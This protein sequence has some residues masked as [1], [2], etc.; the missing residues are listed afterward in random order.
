M[1]HY[2]LLFWILGLVLVSCS[3]DVVENVPEYYPFKDSKS[4]NWGL[5]SV[6]GKV[7]IA[8][9]FKQEPSPVI[10]GIFFVAKDNYYEIYSVSDPTK[11]IGDK[12]K[13]IATFTGKYTP[14]VMKGE[15]IKYI[16]KKGNLKY[17]LPLEYREASIFNKGY[18]LIT[19]KNEDGDLVVGVIDESF[20]I[21]QPKNYSIKEVLSSDKFLATKIGE[22]DNNYY[23][24][25]KK[26]EVVSKFKSDFN[27][28]SDNQ[29]MYIYSDDDNYGVKSID[30][31]ILV[32]AKYKSASFL[33]DQYILAE[34][35][36]GCGIVDV[37]GE[38]VVRNRYM[39]IE[40]LRDGKFIALRDFSEGYGLLNMS[41][42]RIIKYNY[43]YLSFIPGSDYLTGKKSDDPSICI[44]NT[45]GEVLR[46]YACFSIDND[47]H[48][49]VHSDYFDVNAF[50]KSLLYPNEDKKASDLFGFSGMDA[51]SVAAFLGMDQLGHD[52]ISN[53]SGYQWLPSVEETDYEYGSYYYRLGFNRIEEKYEDYSSGYYYPI[54]RYRYASG[55]K[56]QA[57][58]IHVD[59]SYYTEAYN[60]FDLIKEKFGSAMSSLGYST[61]EEY[62]HST[63]YSDTEKSVKVELSDG[64]I[65]LMVSPKK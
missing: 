6:K 63:I 41:E 8:D 25:N 4:D 17:A 47:E 11:P 59:L 3:G 9:E 20:K 52:D 12:Y 35:S 21:F 24:I 56:C 26:L 62:D 33:N 51:Q 28:L 13:E 23:I 18:S 45:K 54:T 29:K 2:Y 39:I 30:G 10:N 31:K 61:S 49:K 53:S 43:N 42:D 40:Q 7:L 44:L 48:M 27:N 34:N 22:E 65:L 38:T 1:K 16:D 58:K 15:G 55:S 36:D 60:H 57:L 37:N 14:S 46:E 19:K 5:V 64:D 50:V 32:R